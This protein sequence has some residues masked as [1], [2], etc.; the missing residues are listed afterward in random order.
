[1]EALDPCPGHR[2]RLLCPRCVPLGFAPTLGRSHDLRS[3]SVTAVRLSLVPEAVP[4]GL[5]SDV[6][7]S[8]VRARVKEVR[9]GGRP[10]GQSDGLESGGL[11]PPSLDLG[12]QCGS[13]EEGHPPSVAVSRAA[14]WV[15]LE[16][17]GQCPPCELTSELCF[18]V[19][20]GLGSRQAPGTGL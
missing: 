10:T 17:G 3:V 12:A 19:C 18:F 8:W 14:T 20:K 16:S 13:K 15:V 5:S 11:R 6:G 2:R 4:V 9:E 7:G 1:M